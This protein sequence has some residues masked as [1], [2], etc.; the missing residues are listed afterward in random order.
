MHLLLMH[1]R[2][3]TSIDSVTVVWSVSVASSIDRYLFLSTMVAPSEDSTDRISGVFLTCIV[4][5]SAT[6]AP[7][8]SW[9]FRTNST[10]T[11]PVGSSKRCIIRHREHSGIF[12][13]ISS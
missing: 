1:G 10:V 2:S 9:S 7:P 6:A 13:S 12:G 8:A 5:G 11:T 4:R 3:L